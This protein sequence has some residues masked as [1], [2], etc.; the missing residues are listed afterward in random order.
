MCEISHFLSVQLNS[1]GILKNKG[2]PSE[3]SHL[4]IS[5]QKGELFSANKIGHSFSPCHT[6]P[7]GKTG[8]ATT[9]NSDIVKSNVGS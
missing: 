8:I 6:K 7:I 9:F 1:Q 3:I 4:P 2:N 5:S